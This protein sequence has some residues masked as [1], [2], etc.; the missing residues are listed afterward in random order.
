M[1]WRALQPSALVVTAAGTASAATMTKEDAS[2]SIDDS[3]EPRQARHDHSQDV[4]AAA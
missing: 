4:W 3:E 2:L 1:L